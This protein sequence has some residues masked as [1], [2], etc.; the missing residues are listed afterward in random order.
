MLRG[1][2]AQG[3]SPIVGARLSRQL[4]TLELGPPSRIALAQRTSERR[5]SSCGKGGNVMRMDNAL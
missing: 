4:Y 2:T 3:A 1:G 5:L